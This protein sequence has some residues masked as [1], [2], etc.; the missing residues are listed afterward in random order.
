[1]KAVRQQSRSIGNFSSRLHGVNAES[2]NLMRPGDY[3][4]RSA[5]LAADGDGATFNKT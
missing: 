3:E 1:M 5:Q 4:K 2:E